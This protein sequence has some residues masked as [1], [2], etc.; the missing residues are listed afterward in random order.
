MTNQL[1]N[2]LAASL[3]AV[4]LWSCNTTEPTP[5]PYESGAYILNS[6]NFTDNNGSITFLARSSTNPATDIFNAA[7]ARTLTGGLQD[8]TEIDGK[9]II[10]VDNSTAGQDKV[11]IVEIGTFKSLTTLKAPDVENPRYVVRAGLN[12][13]YITCW[14]A[15]GSGANFFASPGYVLVVNLASRTVSKKITL[16]KGANRITVVGSEAFVGS[17]GGDRTL[18]VINTETDELKQPG[19]DVGVNTNPI[20]V[21]ANG[22]LWAYV[23]ETNEMIRVNTAS[24]VVDKRLKVGGSPKT[25]G[26]F[27]LSQ[28]KKTFYFVNSFY[29][30]ADNYRQK[31]ETYRFGIDDASIPATSPFI[32]RLFSGLGVDPQ[33][34]IIYAGVTPSYKQAG[35]VIRYQPGGALID[36]V[37]AEIGPSRFFFR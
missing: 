8:Y 13:A 16:P 2:V 15:T 20:D 24:K 29:D 26:S 4:G 9:G 32:G 21:D 18:T 10:L 37:R 27:A 17:D 3:L 25:P 14:G 30:A 7:N 35:Y 19:I 33:T 12:K 31:G 34:G 11:E 28:D 5:S 22:R 23:Q 1:T 6:G 36:S